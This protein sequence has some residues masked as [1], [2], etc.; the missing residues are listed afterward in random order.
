MQDPNCKTSPFDIKSPKSGK[1]K[2]FFRISRGMVRN[3]GYY[4]GNL[5]LA[6][7]PTL[8]LKRNFA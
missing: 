4:Q 1:I 8:Q 5:Q 2:Q 3:L 6:N 7:K